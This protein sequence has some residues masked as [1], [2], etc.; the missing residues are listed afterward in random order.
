V[1]LLS[2]HVDRFNEGVRTGEWSRMLLLF[3]D[4]GELTFS[5]IPVGPFRGRIQRLHVAYER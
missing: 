1:S 4:D 3:A 5:G 2:E